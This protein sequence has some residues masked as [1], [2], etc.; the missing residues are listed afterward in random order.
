MRHR[1]MQLRGQR[2]TRHKQMQFHTMKISQ[3]DQLLDACRHKQ[4]GI[5]RRHARSTVTTATGTLV[6]AC[7]FHHTHSS[8]HCEPVK[9]GIPLQSMFR[10]FNSLFSYVTYPRYVRREKY[11]ALNRFATSM[12]LCVPVTDGNTNIPSLFHVII[13]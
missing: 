3:L 9:H 6:R 13:S 7:P 8:G 4:G 1:S 11:A 5:I 12:H 2:L 10:I